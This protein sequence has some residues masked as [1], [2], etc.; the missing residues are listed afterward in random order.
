MQDNAFVAIDVETANCWLASICQIGLAAVMGDADS[1]I[2][3]TYVNPETDFDPYNIH[4]HG[5]DESVVAD[6]PCLPDAWD[7]LGDQL[8]DRIVVSHTAFDR[9]AISQACERY[10]L[11]PIPCRWLDS[12]CVA[13]R[14]WSQFA[15]R[16]YGLANLASFLGIPMTRHHDAGSDAW[17]AAQI[18][19]R[20]IEHTGL[21]AS[22]WLKRVRGPL[23]P[24]TR[25]PATTQSRA[26][27]VGNPDGPLAG[28]VVVF[29]GALATGRDHAAS[30]AIEA[31]CDVHANVTKATT[32][33]VVGIQDP[34]RLVGYDKSSKHRRAEELVAQGHPIRIICEQDLER[35]IADAQAEESE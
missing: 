23:K 3:S 33:L 16:G 21:S 5:I 7:W 27:Q 9:V 24:R 6:A 34:S 31:G 8:A 13:R 35:L 14:A 26:N 19:Q 10:R 32:V 22:D 4:I 20:A 18:M 1:E 29:T 12:A 11:P 2:V 30:L 17:V 28:E 25:R 15:Y